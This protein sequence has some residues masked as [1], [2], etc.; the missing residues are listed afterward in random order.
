MV[1]HLQAGME[2][3]RCYRSNL[4]KWKRKKEK[5]NGEL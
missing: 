1:C 4:E 3:K 2:K 5:P